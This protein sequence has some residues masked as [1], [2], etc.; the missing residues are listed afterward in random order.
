MCR[1]KRNSCR[2]HMCRIIIF[3]IADLSCRF[4]P[5]L[6]TKNADKNIA[7]SN[8]TINPLNPSTNDRTRMGAEKQQLQPPNK[9][10]KQ[11]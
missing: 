6:Y 4:I 3:L 5:I 2:L 8:E 11:L 9:G 7:K 1:M 10:I